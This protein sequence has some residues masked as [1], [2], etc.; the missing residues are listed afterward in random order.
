MRHAR[1]KRGLRQGR[2]RECAEGN[3]PHFRGQRQLQTALGERVHQGAHADAG[4]RPHEGLAEFQN[5]VERTGVDRG[6]AVTAHAPRLRV[7]G[8]H[9][10]NGRRIAPGFGE[11]GRKVFEA[12]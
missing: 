4:L 7:I 11:D 1:A 12:L 10:S 3:L 9:H 5:F 6:A 8:A 2:D